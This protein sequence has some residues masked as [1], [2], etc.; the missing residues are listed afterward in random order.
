MPSEIERRADLK[1]SMNLTSKEEGEIE[2]E[3]YV[4]H[5]AG[6]AHLVRSPKGISP[7]RTVRVPTL[8]SVFTAKLCLA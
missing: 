4:H 3:Y 7:T 5:G 1:D 2:Y 6:R 8:A